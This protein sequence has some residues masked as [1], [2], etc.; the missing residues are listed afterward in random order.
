MCAAYQ[1]HCA[2]VFVD[3][4]AADLWWWPMR[5]QTDTT[6][7]QGCMKSTESTTGYLEARRDGDDDAD[8]DDDEGNAL[9]R[10][11]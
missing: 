8:N 7:T 3:V 11:Y 5:A 2:G 10:C 6:A 1:S 4:S 9:C